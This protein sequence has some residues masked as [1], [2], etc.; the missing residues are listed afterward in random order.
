[1]RVENAWLDCRANERTCQDIVLWAVRMR[2]NIAIIG[3]KVEDSDREHDISVGKWRGGKVGSYTLCGY[4][5]QRS[6]PALA[7]RPNCIATTL[8]EDCNSLTLA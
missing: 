5:I 3:L 8:L 6:L 4:M 1:M 2:L 7:P